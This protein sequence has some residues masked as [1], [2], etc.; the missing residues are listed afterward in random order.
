MNKAR[1][2]FAMFLVLFGLMAQSAI[3][4]TQAQINA[5]VNAAMRGDFTVIATLA[6]IDP[7]GA[8]DAYDDILA[9]NNDTA[10]IGAFNAIA[11]ANAG[12]AGRLNGSAQRSGISPEAKA[13]IAGLVAAFATSR[14]GGG[15]DN[16]KGTDGG[17]G[18]GTS[19]AT[20]N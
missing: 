20:G 15:N 5:A 4:A 17:N 18:G 10:A 12:L 3:A 11:G 2:V 9:K 7:E 13:T 8:L 19:P 6:S 1:L 16:N 14:S